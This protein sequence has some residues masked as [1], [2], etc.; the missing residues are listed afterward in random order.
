MKARDRI[1]SDIS[2]VL[3]GLMHSADGFKK[4]ISSSLEV[5]LTKF[6]DKMGYVPRDEFD[7][8]VKRIEKLEEMLAGTEKTPKKKLLSRKKAK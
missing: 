1:F 4:E 2:G 8:L 5:K 7:I 3:G 6:C